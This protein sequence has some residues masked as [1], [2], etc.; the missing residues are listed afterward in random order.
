MSQQLIGAHEYSTGELKVGVPLSSL[1][2]VTGDSDIK[3]FWDPK[4]RG[5]YRM[6]LGR[7]VENPDTEWRA[8][9]TLRA[10]LPVLGAAGYRRLL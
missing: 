1:D 8:G 6:E 2:E 7:S 5:L 9:G 4:I 3:G 10:V